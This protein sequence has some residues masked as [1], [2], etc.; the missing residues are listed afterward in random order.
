MKGIIFSIFNEM[1]E[2]KFGLA[3]WD[4]MIEETKPISK[5]V[6]TSGQT[7]NESELFSYVGFLSK[8][9]NKA[10][11][12]L[13]RSFGSFMATKLPRIYPEF[14]TKKTFK[15]FLK[16]IDSVIHVEVKKLYPGA[17]LPSFSYED[18]APNK[19]IMIYKSPRKL[20]HLAEGLIA[21]SAQHYQTSYLMKQSQCLH[22]NDPH[23]RFEIDFL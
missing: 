20:C 18:P 19:L 12:E 8:I 10:G 22:K 7:Y 16:S 17:N 2:E 5:G 3:M 6:Y 4:R 15:E 13:V 9:T 21:G 14:Y 11:Q 1:I 23:C